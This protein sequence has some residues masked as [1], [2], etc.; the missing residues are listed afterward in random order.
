MPSIT[1]EPLDRTR[2]SVPHARNWALG[3]LLVLPW[4]TAYTAGPVAN[5]WSWLV[6]AS[7]AV[8]VWLFWRRLDAGLIATTWVLAAAISA[9]MGLVQY[10]GLA[11]ALSPWIS[12]TGAGEAFANLRQRNQFATLTSIGLLALIALLAR[13]AP[14]SRVPGWAH[15]AMALLALGNAASSSRTGLL[16]WLLIVVLTAAW[17]LRGQRRLALF[18][19]QALLA[20]GLA[21]VAL[22][23]LLSAATGLSNA[24]LLGRLAETP[25]CGSRRALWSNVLH[26]IGQKP[27]LGLGWGELDS[28]H[29]MTL[30]PGARFCDILDNAHNL[31]LHLAVELGIPLAMT[32][33]AGAG[34]VV[35]RARPWRETDPTRQMAWGVLAVIMLHS[36]LEYPLWY[37]PFQM[38]FGLCVWMLWPAPRERTAGS[39]QYA[40]ASVGAAIRLVAAT[41]LLAAV[42]YA[43]WDYHRI[44]QLYLAPQARDPAYRDDTLDKVR[45]SWLFRN[46]VLFAELTTTS[47]QPANARWTFDTATAL[48]HYSPEPRVIEKV[49]ESAVMLRRDEE[50][51]LHLVRYRAAFPEDYKKWRRTNG[52]GGPQIDP[53]RD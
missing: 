47:L 2:S 45:G 38:A 39:G 14:S 33:C 36:M 13:Q 18:A 16:Q 4:L 26:L 27:W 31:P 12:Q 1:T 44:S 19:L 25:G 46:Q 15:A 43:A 51:L 6:S 37:G 50:A 7:C 23:W 53:E 30:Y 29:Y 24:G 40:R 41:A 52:L 35:W 11:Q 48:L 28:A 21:V 5:A 3:A 20:Y 42:A 10:F 9:V 32:V 8:L 34:W 17:A 49:I 22:P